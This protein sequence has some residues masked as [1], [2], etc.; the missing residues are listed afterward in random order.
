MSSGYDAEPMTY[1]QRQQAI[2][3][4]AS[5]TVSPGYAS[6]PV[7]A[8]AYT[9]S[10]YGISA[11]AYDGRSRS[12]GE[13]GLGSINEQMDQWD[14]LVIEMANKYG[15]DPALIKSIIYQESGGDPNATSYAGAMGL[16]QLMPGT[17]QEVAAQLGWSSY[18]PYDPRQSVEMGTYYLSNLISTY[19]LEGPTAEATYANGL[20]AYNWGIGNYL[21]SGQRGNV[22]AGNYS[23]L[24]GETQNYV[25]NILSMYGQISNGTG[26]YNGS[27]SG[28][29][30]SGS[31]LSAQEQ[32]EEQY[33]NTFAQAEIYDI[34][35]IEYSN[36]A[37]VYDPDKYAGYDPLMDTSVYDMQGLARQ[38]GESYSSQIDKYKADVSTASTTSG[39]PRHNKQEFNIDIVVGGGTDAV[40][41]TEAYAKAV[42]EA[43]TQVTRE[44]YGTTDVIGTT[45][46]NSNS[47]RY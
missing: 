5:S 46:Y 13:S 26:V 32:I 45:I 19:G 20:A 2:N 30:H 40:A 29:S 23:G 39:N 35:S 24:P 21:N 3:Y 43:I 41:R 34:G 47:S 7:S 22:E 9:N 44:Y 11:A 36:G 10:D 15:M 6:N 16:M 42:Q 28:S 17:A 18:D 27:G 4:G 14:D 38:I 1:S 12:G 31:G 33:K 8:A 25:S 37:T